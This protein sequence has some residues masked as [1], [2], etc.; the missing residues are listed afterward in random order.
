MGTGALH[1]LLELCSLGLQWPVLRS[2]QRVLPPEQGRASAG[3]QRRGVIWAQANLRSLSPGNPSPP[4]F[5]SS[6]LHSG[7]TEGPLVNVQA[8][9]SSA[10]RPLRDPADI[11]WLV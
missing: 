9:L 1:N 7:I 4:L 10:E 3:L 6:F 2:R 8:W 5:V 11:L